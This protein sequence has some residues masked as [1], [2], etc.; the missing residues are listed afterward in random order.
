MDCRLLATGCPSVTALRAVT[1]CAVG[2][3][4][5]S[6]TLARLLLWGRVVL[7]KLAA[8]LLAPCT[9]PF[10]PVK[11][12]LTVALLESDRICNGAGTAGG[13]MGRVC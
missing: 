5:L 4:K 3:E 6:I 11:G 10:C 13:E 7:A 2:G 1:S 12:A 9:S 8:G